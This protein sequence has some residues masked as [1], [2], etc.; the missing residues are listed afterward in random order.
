MQHLYSISLILLSGCQA[1]LS[2]TE[3]TILRGLQQKQKL[4]FQGIVDLNQDPTVDGL[5]NRKKVRR[6]LDCLIALGLVVELNRD[7][8]KQGRSL[9]FGLTEKGQAQL[10]RAVLARVT[11]ATGALREI[12]A[13]LVSDPT[14]LWEWQRMIQEKTLQKEPTAKIKERGFYG[15]EEDV[16]EL[17]LAQ[18]YYEPLEEATRNMIEIYLLLH[19]SYRQFKK[20]PRITKRPV[21]GILPETE[22][23]KVW[24][25]HPFEELKET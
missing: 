12:T 3:L 5:A 20:E 19:E 24:W 8:W 13:P 14:A 15:E 4:N 22:K 11:L 10:I 25:N 2:E 16:R 7:E 9:Y 6:I 21:V 1:L 17:K 18:A 23:L